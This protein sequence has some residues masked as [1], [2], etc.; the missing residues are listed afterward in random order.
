MAPLSGEQQRHSL[1]D[2]DVS[3]L[4]LENSRLAQENASLQQALLLMRQ[5]Q[6]QEREWEQLQQQQEHLQQSL[7]SEKKAREIVGSPVPQGLTDVNLA[8]L[9]LQATGCN[10]PAFFSAVTQQQQSA[11][12][13][14]VVALRN[15]DGH[16]S[17]A[18]NSSSRET[19]T[20]VMLR[21]LPNNYTREM[22][23]RLLESQGFG[24]AITFVYLPIDFRSKA[25]LGYA[26]VDLVDSEWVDRFWATFDGFANWAIPSRKV[27]YVS[28]SGPS[29]GLAAHIE[30]YRNS[31]VMHSSVP[32]EYKPV[33][34][35][36]GCRVP[37]PEPTRS[38]RVPRAR[39]G[40]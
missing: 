14:E 34:M 11:G 9:P 18:S 36:G 16:G 21:N 33:I 12:A 7:R 22:L 37:F 17:C 23:L 6:E 4:V 39:Q 32:D 27:C 31:P 19:R 40:H 3:S 15:A 30:R 2:D 38:I 5:Q 8:W 29:Q 10:H 1:P 25:A 35:R 24:G 26:F 13:S 28:W 20:T